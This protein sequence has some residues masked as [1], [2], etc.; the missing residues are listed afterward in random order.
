MTVKRDDITK[1]VDL[2]RVYIAR[3][4]DIAECVVASSIGAGITSRCDVERP[5]RELA[6]G[7]S[8]A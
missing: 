3:G 5:P 4:I 1:S 6:F 7:N 8:G 2:P